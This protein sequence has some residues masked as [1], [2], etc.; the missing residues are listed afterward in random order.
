MTKK[1]ERR[2]EL[3]MTVEEW[4]AWEDKLV[5]TERETKGKK[6]ILDPFAGW[7]ERK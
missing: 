6:R 3:G 4:Q 2:I 5:K 7:I 1:D